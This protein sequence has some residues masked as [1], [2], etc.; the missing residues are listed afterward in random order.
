MATALPPPGNPFTAIG[1]PLLARSLANSPVP[2]WPKL[3]LPQAHSVA[4]AATAR[5]WRMPPAIATVFR[6]PGSGSTATGLGLLVPMLPLPNSP[7]GLDPHAH[8]VP[9]LAKAR[10]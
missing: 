7:S 5:Q 4:A 9:S 10:L 3:L 6:L 8:I 2:N 1:L